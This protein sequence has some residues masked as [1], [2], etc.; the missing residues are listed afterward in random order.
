MGTNLFRLTVMTL[1]LLVSSSLF[2]AS[3]EV[4]LKNVKTD[5]W[6]EDAVVSLH[7]KNGPAPL[8]DNPPLEVMDQVNKQFVPRVL[9]VVLGTPVSFPNK[10]QIRHHVYSIDEVKPF[11]L[12]L[13]SG[14]PAEPIVFDLVGE[15]SL[16]CNIHDHMSGYIYV[17]DTPWFAR[18]DKDGLASINNIPDGEYVLKVWHPRIKGKDSYNRAVVISNGSNNS[19]ELGLNLRRS[20][21]KKA[22]VRSRSG[23]Y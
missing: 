1:S 2:A 12:P 15:V 13:Y 20:F 19:M 9:P 11:E 10:D 8:P 3:L 14:T 6:V 17:L 16:G 22:R 5:K 7:P 23:G 4:K 18:S 21:K